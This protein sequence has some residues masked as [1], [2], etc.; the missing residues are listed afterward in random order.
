MKQGKLQKKGIVFIFVLILI[1]LIGSDNVWA[2]E[3]NS[4]SVPGNPTYTNDAFYYS[5]QYMWKV[6]LFVAKSDTVY[7]KEGENA[8]MDDFYRIGDDAVYI[9]PVNNWGQWM[10]GKRP[11]SQIT[12]IFYSKDNKVDTLQ[13]LKAKGGDVNQL[14]NVSLT[15]ITGINIFRD[16]NVPKVPQLNDGDVYDNGVIVKSPDMVGNIAVVKDYFSRDTYAYQILNYF[17]SK[18]GKSPE[19]FMKGMTFTINGETKSDWNPAGLLP[20]EAS[21]TNNDNKTEVN[22]TS[23]LQW[24]VVYEPVSIV[25]VKDTGAAGTAYYGYALTATDFAV[26]QVKHQM[27][28]R[29]DETQWSAWAG[30]QPDAWKPNDQRQHV[31]RLAF[32]LMGNSLITEKDWYGL[33][34]S[35]GYIDQNAAIPNNRWKSD[36]QIKYGGW[37]MARL[38]AP[39]AAKN[40]PMDQTYRSDTDVIYSCPIY[41]NKQAGDGGDPDMLTVT[42]TI[43]GETFTDKVVAP[44][45]S[46]AISYFKWH[47]PTVNTETTYDL[48]IQV[49]PFPSATIGNIEP[50]HTTTEASKIFGGYEYVHQ[51]I[52]VRPLAEVTPP[53][54]KVDDTVPADFVD[55]LV[56]PVPNEAATSP[57]EIEAPK[58]NLLTKVTAP[59]YYTD[60]AVTIEVITNIDTEFITLNNLD[61]TTTKQLTEQAIGQGILQSVTKK[62]AT[63][64]KIWVLNYRPA[65]LGLNHYSVSPTN[66]VKGTGEP[67]NFDLEVV[68]DPDTPFIFDIVINPLKAV[69]TLFEEVITTPLTYDVYFETNGGNAI[70]TQHVDYNNLVEQPSNPSKEG[71]SFQGWF[72]DPE[73]NY[74]WDFATEKVM[75]ISTIYAKWSINTYQVQFDPQGGTSTYSPVAAQYGSNV[76]KPADP[77]RDGYT[78]MGWFS[79]VTCE[80]PWN[81]D[82]NTVKADTTIYGKWDALAYTVTYDSQG[83]ND[84][85]PQEADYDALITAP[86][87]PMKNGFAFAGWY[88]DASCTNVWTWASDRVKG[89]MTLY[90]KWVINIYTVNFDTMGGSAVA[91][92]SVQH[93][94]LA[95]KPVDP[96]RNGYTFGGWFSDDA[97]TNAW[98]FA[99][100]RVG[101]DM[102]IYAKW[103]ANEA[104]I[105]FVSNGGNTIAPMVATTDALIVNTAMPPIAKDGYLFNGWYAAADFSGDVVTSLPG[106]Y[107]IGTT[108]YYASWTINQYA[109]VFM[110]NGGS[111]VANLNQDFDTLIAEPTTTRTGYTFAGWFRDA[112]LV[113]SWNFATDKITGAT[114]L[115]AKWQIN[116]YTV[117]FEENS[118][119]AVTDL[120]QDF[121][122]TIV[123]PSTTRYGYTLDGWYK[124]AGMTQKWN[125][126]TNTIQGNM[127]LYAKWMEDVFRVGDLFPDVNLA[128]AV[129][130]EM[131]KRPERAS[132]PL[133]SITSKTVVQADLD[134][135]TNLAAAG[136]AIATIE[137]IGQ[138]KNLTTIDLSNN[139]ISSLPDEL[140]SLTKLT[141]LNLCDNNINA[142]P[143]SCYLLTELTDLN[144]AGNSITSL[145]DKIGYLVKLK[146]LN[147]SGNALT[148]LPATLWDLT[149]LTT[150]SMSGNAI[151]TLSDEIGNLTKLTDLD[152]SS[153]SLTAIPA[154]IGNLTNLVNLNASNNSIGFMPSTYGTLTQLKNFNFK[155]NAITYLPYAAAQGWGAVET[156]DLSENQLASLP[157]SV[158]SLAKVKSF[159]LSNNNLSILPDALTGLVTL[160][161]LNLSNNAGII[162]LPLAMGNLTGMTHL[163][164]TG[165]GVTQLPL[166]MKDKVGITVDPSGLP[167]GYTV[168][169]DSKGGTAV[170]S[171]SAD[172]DTTLTKPTDPTRTGYNFY[173]WT[174]DN[175]GTTAWDFLSDRVQDIMTLYGVWLALPAKII[176]VE[177]GGSEIPDMNGYTDGEI[178]PTT[179]PSVERTGYSLAGFYDNAGF[180]GTA[181]TALPNKYPIGTTTYYL[182]WTANPSA[183]VFEENGGD[184]VADLNGVTDQVLSPT[185]MPTV[186]RLGYTFKGWFAAA[187]FSGAEV[188]VLPGTYPPKA[189]TTYYAKWEANPSTITFEENGGSL[190]TDL[191]GLAGGSISPTTLPTTTKANCAFA[192]WY[193]NAAFTGDALTKLPDNYPAGGATYYAR[194][195][196][197]VTFDVQGG[198]VVAGITADCGKVMTAPSSPSL[199]GYVFKGWFK[200]SA[201]TTGWNFASDTVEGNVTLYAKWEEGLPGPEVPLELWSWTQINRVAMLGLGESYFDVGETKNDVVNGE[202]LTFQIYGF[203]HDKL[204]DGTSN[205]TNITFGLKNLMAAQKRM[206]PSNTNYYGWEG[207]EI[208]GWTNGITTTFAGTSYLTGT[209]SLQSQLPSDLKPIIK[210]VKKYT[211]GGFNNLALVTSTDK[212]F[213]FSEKE[214]NGTYGMSLAGE[215][216]QYQ[217]FISSSSQ[218][219]YLSNGS[220]GSAWWWLRSPLSS[221]DYGY[222]IITNEGVIGNYLAASDLGVNFGF[223]IGNAPTNTYP[224]TYNANGGSAVSNGTGT[225]NQLITAPTAPTKT[226]MTFG[227]WYKDAG[228]TQK[229]DFTT[230]KITGA[231]TL[232]AKWQATITFNSQGGTVVAPLITD[233][234]KTFSAPASPSKD[235]WVFKGW[236][237]EAGCLAAWNFAVDQ[238]TMNTTL[239]AKWEAGLPGPEVPL[240]NWSWDQINRVAMLGLGQTY[241]DV[242][243]TKKDVVNGETLTFQIYGFNH[244]DLAD[245]GGKSN[246]TFGLKDLYNTAPMNPS[247][248][249]TT[250][251][252]WD[253]SSLRAYLNGVITPHQATNYS[254]TSVLSMLPS[255]LRTII[256]PVK[257]YT[258]GGYANWLQVISIDT[259]FA[260]SYEELTGASN[261]QN[262]HIYGAE[263]YKYPIFT[264]DA[265][266]VKK[267]YGTAYNWWTRSAIYA[268]TYSVAYG[269][270][271][272]GS[273]GFAYGQ[274]YSNAYS[275]SGVNFGFCLGNAPTN[276]YTVTYNSNGG[277]A[278]TPTTATLNTTIN[279]PTAP[280]KAN[281]IFDGWYK[282]A[283]CTQSWN[284]ASDK[285][286]GATTLYAKWKTLPA[287]GQPLS[288]YTWEEIA[289]IANEGLGDTYFNIGDTKDLTIA[290]TSEVITMQIYD[291][292]HDDLSDGSGKANITFGMKNVMR[293]ENAYNTYLYPNNNGGWKNTT[294]RARLN[295]ITTTNQEIDYANTYNNQSIFYNLPTGV[296]SNIKEIKKYSSNGSGSLYTTNDKLFLFSEKEVTGGNAGSLIG[297]GDRYAIFT[298]TSSV[299]KSNPEVSIGN[300]SWLLRSPTENLTNHLGIIT[301]YGGYSSLS[302]GSA[303][304]NFGFCMGTAKTIPDVGTALKDCS[305]QQVVNVANAGK[306]DDYWNIGDTKDMTLSTG[307]VVTMQVYDF[308]HD[309]KSDGTGKT[310]ITF[311]TKNLLKDS[312][313]MNPSNSNVGGWD[314]ST[315]R[316]SYLNGTIYGYIPQDIKAEIKTVAKKTSTGS[317]QSTIITSSDNLFLFS[318][319]ELFGVEKN[320]Y[321]GE[322]YQYPVFSDN[323]SRIKKLNNGIGGDAMYWERSPSAT[324]N[325]IFGCTNYGN[326]D[327]YVAVASQSNGVAF[328]FSFGTAPS[329]TI[330]FDTQGGT[331]VTS[332]TAGA[333]STITAPSTPT[334][335]GQTFAGWFKDVAGTTEWNFTTDKV[336]GPTT[337]YAKWITLP[338]VGTSLEACRWDQI[339]YISKAGLA[340]TYFD[341]GNT[342]NITLS[343]SEVLTMQIYDFNHDDKSDG[344]GKAGITFGTKDLM[345]ARQTLSTNGDNSWSTSALRSWLNDTL[346]TQF[347]SQ[348]PI[349]TVTKKTGVGNGAVSGLVNTSER[350][351]LFSE[352][353]IFGSNMQS[354]AGEG[355]KYPVFTNGASRIKK[356]NNGSGSIELYCLRS[357]YSGW[358]NKITGVNLS[359]DIYNNWPSINW[360]IAFGFC[361]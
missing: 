348:I 215:G 25:Y 269:F 325:G 41:S 160:Q 294:I 28:W 290:N 170:A 273:D 47:T 143:D 283:G 161:D 342:K 173:Q 19:D 131:N 49:S 285:V 32:L 176:F 195:Q 68:E 340:D 111:D 203:N 244:D 144:L 357:P 146:M 270:A 77:V 251:G 94:S 216:D 163:N 86:T 332:K 156:L 232:Y 112:E 317:T 110:E 18:S 278:V 323:N 249:N 198:S 220:G 149:E 234:Y 61:N 96:T 237:K 145:S 322:G 324:Q 147:L 129:R 89:D 289:I 30:Q 29:Y 331:A 188:T 314:Q 205:K 91:S 193:D 201:G 95:T 179:L 133:T 178:A 256:K 114:T 259:L 141:S 261:T 75:G 222:R 157:V 206:A 135:V 171:A 106:K 352:V 42:Y 227:G 139:S 226:N 199:D 315:M 358:S 296:K 92:Q 84:I 164:V 267:A 210:S 87:P 82:L 246:I 360:G 327:Y 109:I 108:T 299:I 105:E 181:L 248:F 24:L 155:H 339:A 347:S 334:K 239:Y 192:G 300:C 14:S 34:K 292:D 224:V 265:S 113:T 311:G 93:D 169:Y 191:T 124:D 97:C 45:N 305:W 54:P 78:F 212:L 8:T 254:T 127:T 180:T 35:K 40:E 72:K 175:E 59:P 74:S 76:A 100:N 107:P 69:Y 125:F 253:Q 252:G 150:L 187:D 344:S 274:S 190:V 142:V 22:T 148:G 60:E 275:Y 247:S 123:Q 235:G 67:S 356:L 337:L 355:T 351:F 184:A 53:D 196:A 223:A 204:A 219:K 103:T 255:N 12:N 39:V 321:S 83:G 313:Q 194:W 66:S 132:N 51:T 318:E 1:I 166:S 243:E 349:K 137:G 264:T 281:A 359:G 183:I 333:N 242:G 233:T 189:T 9:T 304:T 13:E 213:L 64:E 241:F 177:N 329:H 341:V 120:T 102:T 167:Y 3:D 361:V 31:S 197:T 11:A 346:T 182:N 58:I 130:V 154:S 288:S 121:N 291:F 26:M 286:T 37:G 186:T 262:G 228:L 17:A 44:M 158:G 350:V 211:S 330:D 90:A 354:I 134:Y 63:K 284:F 238:P 338:P 128:E 153:A 200:D 231:T 316:K 301:Q 272:I 6:S 319:V 221:G 88:K 140:G 15:D 297:E 298:N 225:L 10:A 48:K 46:E 260:F 236:Y 353:E 266:R 185:T 52:T 62:P 81:F 136:K 336:T 122:T 343:T 20:M 293:W 118:G 277:S 165:T 80:T 33:E 119:S 65:T 101:K 159:N 328:G 162:N 202:T 174:R 21:D 43:N 7:L 115:Y 302:S 2:M 168:T 306:G 345:V 263:G 280:T 4:A 50:L 279:A 5:D 217:V 303:Y 218:V 104:R 240:E 271:Q 73:F 276:T 38:K 98:D 326:G 208:R 309:D 312:K 56:P 214:V 287:A 79:D 152:I 27:D 70:D 99:V 258:V 295:G 307:E 282:D 151:G 57:D 310:N 229:W 138:L 209:T 230:D 36:D 71:Y 116:S 126:G 335:S 268:D 16:A 250:M 245:G 257:K 207:S 117:T 308:N 23:Q 172:F 85:T 55:G 320:A